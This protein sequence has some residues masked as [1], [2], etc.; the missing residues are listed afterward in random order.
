MSRLDS[1]VR[2]ARCHFGELLEYGM[3]LDDAIKYSIEWIL[4]RARD[5]ERS[6]VRQQVLLIFNK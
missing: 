2:E 4:K 3:T 1:Y 5:A 6:I